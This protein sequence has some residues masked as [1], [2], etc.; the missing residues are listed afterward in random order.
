VAHDDAVRIANRRG[1]EDKF[2]SAHGDSFVEDFALR[3]DDGNPVALP[4][5]HYKPVAIFTRPGA[6]PLQRLS[7]D[8][9]LLDAGQVGFYLYGRKIIITGLQRLPARWLYVYHSYFPKVEKEASPVL[10]PDWSLEAMAY[11]VG[12]QAMA[13]RAVDDARY[14]QYTAPPDATG[15]PLHNPYLKVAEFFEKRYYA[16]VAQHVDDDESFRW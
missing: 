5:Y 4:A 12:V 6:E 1:T 7:P 16:I 2:A 3:A 10:A 11:Y 13:Q 8:L 14:R 15:N 9:A